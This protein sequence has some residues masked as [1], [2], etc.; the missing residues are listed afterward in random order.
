VEMVEGSGHG[1]ALFIYQGTKWSSLTLAST[2][3]SRGWLP[4]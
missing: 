3:T 1:E 2:L 4:S